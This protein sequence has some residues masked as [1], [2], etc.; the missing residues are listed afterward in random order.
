LTRDGKPVVQ[1]TTLKIAGMSCG[2]CVRHVTRA[3]DGMTGV[4]HVDVDIQTH[5]ATVEH[6]PA[7]VD[8]TSLIS[9]V[10]DAGYSARIGARDVETGPMESPRCCGSAV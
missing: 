6:L 8:E 7:W 5:Q 9:A 4:V 2:V 1:T 3:L 10:T